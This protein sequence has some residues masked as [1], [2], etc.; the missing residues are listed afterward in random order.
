MTDGA[1][2][3][4]RWPVRLPELDFKIVHRARVKHEAADALSR[5]L[6]TGMCESPLEANIPEVTITKVPPGVK[7]KMDHNIL[8]YSSR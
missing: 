8:A 4:A 1:G 2:K 6:T 7:A 3:L 5:L